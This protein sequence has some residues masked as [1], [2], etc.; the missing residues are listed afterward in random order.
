MLT[1]HIKYVRIILDF[2]G[3]NTN[4][5]LPLSK[6]CMNNYTGTLGIFQ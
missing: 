4:T 3:M 2:I 6:H 5:S 1:K